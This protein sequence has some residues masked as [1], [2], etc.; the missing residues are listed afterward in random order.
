MSELPGG[1]GCWLGVPGGGGYC[2]PILDTPCNGGESTT[3]IGVK[4][5]GSYWFGIV[6]KEE[7]ICESMSFDLI[8]GYCRAQQE[9]CPLDGEEE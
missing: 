2:D 1:E 7:G 3:D 4:R 6:L 9:D 8:V 5:F